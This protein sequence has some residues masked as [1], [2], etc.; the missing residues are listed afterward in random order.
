MSLKKY[1]IW[2]FVTPALR[3]TINSVIGFFFT[4]AHTC[5]EITRIIQAI[6]KNKERDTKWEV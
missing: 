4:T 5:L 1:F 6:F 2:A 3:N